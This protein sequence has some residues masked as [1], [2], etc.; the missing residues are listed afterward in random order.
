MNTRLT[1]FLLRV[2][3]AL[4]LLY[5]AIASFLSPAVWASFFPQWM[6]NIIP[7]TILLTIFSICEIILALWLL[8][9]KKACLAGF[10]SALVMLGIIFTNLHSLDLVFRDI[11]I[12]FAGL[13]I[14]TLEKK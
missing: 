5:A 9:N 13:A 10:V 14:I 7:G 3:V 4:S 11:P 12:L 6:T 1:S 2:G 8:S